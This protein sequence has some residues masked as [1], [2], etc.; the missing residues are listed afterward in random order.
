MIIHDKFAYVHFPKTGGHF[1]V[2]WLTRYFDG[3]QEERPPQGSYGCTNDTHL[4]VIYLENKSI[5][6]WGMIRNPFDFYASWH[7]NHP[8]GLNF[9][10]FLKFTLEEKDDMFHYYVDFKQM[11]RL[12]IGLMTWWFIRMFYDYEPI[13]KMKSVD[14]L[15]LE[16]EILMDKILL[17]EDFNNE[18]IKLFN[19]HIFPLTLEQLDALIQGRRKNVSDHDYWKD[20]YDEE[21]VKLVEHKDRLIFKMYP[22][23][24]YDRSSKRTLG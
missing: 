24:L 22:H 15:D 21:L 17:Y 14:G 13:F 7:G 11:E 16:K 12:D 23:Y 1:I 2:D 10:R 5:Y 4:P 6:K 8:D 9:R 20:C 18:I 3:C 19:E